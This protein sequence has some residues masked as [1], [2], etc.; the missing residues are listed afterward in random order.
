MVATQQATTRTESLGSSSQTRTKLR[1]STKQRFLLPKRNRARTAILLQQFQRQHKE[2][3]RACKAQL[4]RKR[5][6]FAGSWF[7]SRARPKPIGQARLTLV[8]IFKRH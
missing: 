6:R 4:T 7:S 3:R 1:R 2:K 8:R 5:H